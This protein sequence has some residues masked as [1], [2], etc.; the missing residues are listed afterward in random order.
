MIRRVIARGLIALAGGLLIAGMA[1]G[2]GGAR[3]R[4]PLPFRMGS[5]ALVLL[6][7]LLMAGPR[8][9][10]G[11]LS[12]GGMACGLLGDLIMARVIPLPEHVIGGM[13]AFGVGHGMYMRAT[14][15]HGAA[16]GLTQR[17]V[18][19][20]GLL[21]GWLAALVGWR[22][23]AYSPERGVLINRAA[24]GYA[25][26]L[27]SMAGLAGALAAQDRRHSPLAAGGALFLLSDLILA[28]ELFRG[29]SFPLIGDLVWLTYLSGQA[30]IVD[31]LSCPADPP[32]S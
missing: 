22:A 5:S 28:G 10:I 18:G 3:N 1:R 14:S 16:L 7:A 21:A 32:P 13:A 15:L 29:T 12:A 25:L 11:R 4:I 27:G 2:G 17:R 23:L 9:Q 8:G 31:S 19:A 24:L 20:A 26:L 30:L 6:A